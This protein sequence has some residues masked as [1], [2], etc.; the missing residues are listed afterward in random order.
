[1]GL[2]PDQKIDL[3]IAYI[4][5]CDDLLLLFELEDILYIQIQKLMEAQNADVQE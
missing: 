5:K 1:M 2:T 3:A 4:K